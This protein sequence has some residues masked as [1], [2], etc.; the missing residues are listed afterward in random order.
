MYQD[1]CLTVESTQLY[2]YG[3][4][5]QFSRTASQCLFVVVVSREACVFLD[6]ESDV[7]L[8]SGLSVHPTL[9]RPYSFI[10]ALCIVLSH[11]CFHHTLVQGSVDFMSLDFSL[12]LELIK[13]MRLYLHSKLNHNEKRKENEWMNNLVFVCC[14]DSW[15][16]FITTFGSL[17]FV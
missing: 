2:W 13:A 5:L 14:S 7:W 12:T 11:N 3:R 9:Q 17:S 8:C 1:C 15:T 4:E 10:H 16:C 6:E